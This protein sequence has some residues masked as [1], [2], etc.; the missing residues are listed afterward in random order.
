MSIDPSVLNELNQIEGVTARADENLAKLCTFRTGGTADLF[1]SVD[2]LHG[3]RKVFHILKA[4]NIT[5]RIIGKGSN[6]LFSDLGTS[7]A[8][9]RLGSGFQK[10]KVDGGEL[11]AGAGANLATVA[12]NA[13]HN[14]L[15]GF[16]FSAGIPGTIGGAI[17]GNAGA[18]GVD[19]LSI[20]DKLTILSVD[21]VISS[22]PAH[23]ISYGYRRTDID[24]NAVVLEAA[25]HLTHGEKD[26]I[27]DLM[28]R[29]FETRRSSQPYGALTAGSVF[30]NPTLGVSA[31]KLI[32]DLG[33][34]GLEKGGARV[35]PVHANF[36][37]NTGEAS[38]DDIYYL[39]YRVQQEVY[40][41]KGIVLEPEIKIIGKFHMPKL[42]H[43]R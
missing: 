39:I 10:I 22:V 25:F 36:I 6:I 43:E 26:Q 1:V 17:V 31:G 18:Y 19:I 32:D 13:L 34:K 27:E 28:D 42:L 20:V 40:Q 15:E 29:Y 11:I 8:L 35:S 16:E 14:S 4:A 12:F 5:H 23:D 33:L 9:I 37:E 41:E 21:G 30:K 2:D 24:P 7:H 3:L 38:S